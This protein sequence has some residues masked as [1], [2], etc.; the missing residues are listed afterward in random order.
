[1]SAENI[2]EMLD[3]WDKTA[4]AARAANPAATEEQIYQM[5]AA[6]MNKSLGL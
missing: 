5:T 1:M 3:N 2:K 4:D 6:A